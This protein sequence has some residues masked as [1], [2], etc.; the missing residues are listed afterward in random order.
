MC[1]INKKVMILVESELNIFPS[2]QS[3]HYSGI[4]SEG[5]GWLERVCARLLLPPAAGD[6]AIDGFSDVPSSAHIVRAAADVLR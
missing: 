2:V 1:L 4:L 5:K 3:V 6:K